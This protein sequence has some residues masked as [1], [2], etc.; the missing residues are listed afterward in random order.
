MISRR[1]LLAGGAAALMMS[2]ISWAGN[3]F[4]DSLDHVLLGCNDLQRGIDFVEQQ[5]GVRAVF[6]GVHPG[7]GTQN[8]LLSL[9]RLHYLEIIAPDPN[10]PEVKQFAM[11]KDFRTPRLVTWAAHP[12]DLHA[13][14]KKLKAKGIAFEGPR[15]GSR[16]RPDGRM[17]KWKSLSVD[18]RGG[19]VPFFIQWSPDSP[20][21][22]SDAPAGC[23]LERFYAT[24][25]KPDEL[26]GIYRSIGIEIKVER[27]DKA[28]LHAVIVGPKGKLEVSS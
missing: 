18:D 5:T 8:A 4:P 21:P 7:R 12:G 3:P 24:D 6:G 17:L 2:R 10:Q 16:A 13:I 19:L 20:H 15:D 22:S 14:A 23:R 9:G 28:Q 1:L 27:G 26:Q 11:I 25:P